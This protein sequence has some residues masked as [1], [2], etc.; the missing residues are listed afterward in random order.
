MQFFG[1]TLLSGCH[2]VSCAT[3]VMRSL[4]CEGCD[5]PRIDSH[6]VGTLGKTSSSIKSIW[7]Q[8]LITIKLRPDTCQ[9]VLW[10][11]NCNNKFGYSDQVSLKYVKEIASHSKIWVYIT[12]VCKICKFDWWQKYCQLSR[13][14]VKSSLLTKFEIKI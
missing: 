3:N 14:L 13:I 7:Y 6:L 4:L 5:H 10:I 9:Q 11:L 8:I 2:F 12:L 1:T